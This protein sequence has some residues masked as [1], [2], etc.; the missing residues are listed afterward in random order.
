MD[1][2]EA[3]RK[4]KS[5]RAY[6]NTPVDDNTL[7]AVLEAA[8]LAPSWGNSQTW[9]FIV[10]KDEL[11][12]DKLIETSLRAGNRG[13]DACR[14]APITLVAC[15]ETN[16]AGCR[17]GQG[18]TDKEGYWFMF[19]VAL[20]MQNLVLAAES[21]GLSTVYIGAFDAKKAGEILAVPEGFCV[22]AVTPLGYPDEEPE[23]RPRKE[24]SE[25]I[26]YDRFGSQ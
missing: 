17:D 24:L 7:G 6:K 23:A 21:L 22:V 3:I 19:D 10:V 12:K 15:A 11:I 18:V 20:A 1:V 14:Q 16:K 9:R 25:I 2:M 13:F 4:R 8:R 5:I 26:F